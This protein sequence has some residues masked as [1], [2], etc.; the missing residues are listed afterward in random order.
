MTVNEVLSG[1]STQNGLTMTGIAH[2]IGLT[3]ATDSLKRMVADLVSEGKVIENTGG[4]FVTYTKPSRSAKNEE[5]A[6]IQK[7]DK[8]VEQ[9][10]KP[11]SSVPELPEVSSRVMDGYKLEKLSE[12]GLSKLKISLPNGKS[13]KMN[14]TD[15]LLVIN[16]EPKYVVKSALDIVSAIRNYTTENNL[17]NYTVDD[18]M[19]NKKIGTENDI[20]IKDNH[21]VFLSIK[22]VNKAA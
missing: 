11:K 7:N 13:I 6:T 20:Q 2:K 21:L 4:K 9:I 3:K 19:Q 10:D 16:N 18:I 1:L 17:T 8:V 5:V 12:K 22:K 15:T 14:D